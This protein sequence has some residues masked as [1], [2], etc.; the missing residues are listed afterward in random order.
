MFFCIYQTI[1]LHLL[2]HYILWTIYSHVLLQ[3]YQSL[4][5]L[6]KQ[7]YDLCQPRITKSWFI[8]CGGTIQ[9]LILWYL[10]GPPQLNNPGS[11]LSS[12]WH[13]I[14]SNLIFKLLQFE[15][16]LK[17]Q[18]KTIIYHYFGKQQCIYYCISQKNMFLCSYSVLKY[19]ES[20]SLVSIMRYSI[21]IH[22]DRGSN[23]FFSAMG[24]QWLQ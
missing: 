19:I 20:I 23:C 17:Y 16:N 22:H 10:V 14:V 18:I 24:H 6:W 7:K 4:L 11:Y 21:Y 3:Y 8:N 2:A 13:Y 15:K 5:S 9:I 1:L 12:G